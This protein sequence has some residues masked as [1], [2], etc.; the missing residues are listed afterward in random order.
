MLGLISA[1]PS[2]YARKV[3]IALAEKD[4]PFELITEV[5]WDNATS[6]PKYNPLEK[7]PVLLLED[8]GS[9]YESRFILE[10]LELKYPQPRLLPDDVDEIIAAK[11]VEVL[12]DGICDACV[13]ISGNAGVRKPTRAKP[14]FRASSARWTVGYARS[15]SWPAR[16]SGSSE[17]ASAS[18][19]SRRE[20]CSATSM[21][22][23]PIC[24]GESAIRTS[25]A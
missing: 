10:Y 4:I 5:P 9:V 21:S 15:P 23:S 20:R 3:R 14:G 1:T 7:L 8:G 16:G 13:L 17:T 24:R 2:P 19:T 11:R 22:A 6:T 18:P 12:C 25:F